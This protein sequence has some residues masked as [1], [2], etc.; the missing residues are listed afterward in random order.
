MSTPLSQLPPPTI[1][2]N[3]VQQQQY[4][5]LLPPDT[6]YQ[7]NIEQFTTQQMPP[8][9]YGS[10]DNS[11][12]VDD[13]L[14]GIQDAPEMEN[15]NIDASMFSRSMDP[16]QVPPEKKYSRNKNNDLEF[17]NFG[18]D[19]NNSN[20]SNSMVLNAV[21]INNNSAIGKIYNHAKLPVIVFIVCFLISYPPVNRIVFSA[22]PNL[23]LESGQV[24]IQGVLFKALIGLVLFYIASL[25]I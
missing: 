14:A 2:N 15:S 22:V 13:I 17:E 21:G 3:P 16:S 25:V 19:S 7:G 18:P 12:L 6:R 11:Q 5:P 20:N 1:G 10:Q 24:S 8:P 9:Q 23:L 4:N